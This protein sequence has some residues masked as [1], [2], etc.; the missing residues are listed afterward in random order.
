VSIGNLYEKDLESSKF[1]DKKSVCYAELHERLTAIR[2]KD[3]TACPKYKHTDSVE[4]IIIEFG[5]GN[6]I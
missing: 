3:T 6:L 4:D 2:L 5:E 1:R